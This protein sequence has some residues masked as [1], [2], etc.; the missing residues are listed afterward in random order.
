MKRSITQTD[1]CNREDLDA[2]HTSLV[3]R[4]QVQPPSTN[5]NFDFAADDRST[6]CFIFDVLPEL[7][8]SIT[9]H[10][11]CT[12]A[13]FLG[14]CC[15]GMK[16]VLIRSWLTYGEFGLPNNVCVLEKSIFNETP[17][18]YLNYHH[19][20]S[21]RTWMMARKFFFKHVTCAQDGI[22]STPTTTKFTNPWKYFPYDL[23]N[24]LKIKNVSL[25]KRIV[26]HKLL[27]DDTNSTFGE[28]LLP[29]FKRVILHNIIINHSEI[30][31]L[32]LLH[33]FSQNAC[34]FMLNSQLP[35][36]KNLR[37]TSKFVWDISAEFY[38][39]IYQ[40]ETF[41]K[42]LS[43][44]D[45]LKDAKK[46]SRRISDT[47]WLN[48]CSS[49]ILPIFVESVQAMNYSQYLE[50]KLK[51]PEIFG[52]TI[53][54]NIKIPDKEHQS[55]SIVGEI[56]DSNDH[57]LSVETNDN[58][59]NLPKHLDFDEI[60]NNYTLK[61]MTNRHR[62]KFF[63]NT[64]AK[65]GNVSLFHDL[66]YADPVPENPKEFLIVALRSH[67]REMTVYLTE[68]MDLRLTMDDMWC[69]SKKIDKNKLLSYSYFRKPNK[70]AFVQDVLYFLF[71]ADELQR[72]FEIIDLDFR[73]V[74]DKDLRN[75]YFSVINGIPMV[76]IENEDDPQ[77]LPTKVPTVFRH[78][79]KM[80]PM[81]DHSKQ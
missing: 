34:L 10:L 51:Y 47:Q 75:Y 59:P 70:T 64:L 24:L 52:S 36:S 20:K 19:D 9:R 62:K 1:D 33:F 77:K 43:N 78:F 63:L 45:L 15:R 71:C 79:V 54:Q 14:I 61:L 21:H 26:T 16:D 68:S 23:P 80:H 72:I 65:F 53:T 39:T 42:N 28:L 22:M 49:Q 17:I 67:Q 50:I 40:K 44:M 25:I 3:I 56:S 27:F 55:K 38:A 18:F 35:E 37:Q 5:Y 11:K 66:F 8:Y 29:S 73:T 12:Y 58:D 81:I 32:N 4:N 2:N 48:E 6:L 46:K 74:L 60:P 13:F 76:P 31:A 30:D 41:K 7:C 57:E 69:D